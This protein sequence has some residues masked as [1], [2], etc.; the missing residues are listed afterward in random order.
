MMKPVSLITILLFYF[1]L[2]ASVV[3]AGQIPVAMSQGEFTIA[4]AKSGYPLYFLDEQG[5]AAGLMTDLWRLWAKKQEVAVTFVATD[6]WVESLE[7]VK[8]GEIDIHAGLA[9]TPD[10]QQHFSMSRALFSVKSH[11]YLHQKFSDITNGN[12]LTPYSVGVLKGSSN[13]ETIRKYYPALALKVFDTETALFD[14]ALNGKILAFANTLGISKKYKAHNELSNLFPTAKRINF[15]QDDIVAAVAKDNLALADF[16]EQGL[17]KISTEEQAAIEQ[18]W[19]GLGK[20]DDVLTLAFYTRHAP[21]SAISP[22]GKPQGLFIDLWKLWSKHTGQKID[23][24]GKSLDESIALVKK[25]QVDVVVSYPQSKQMRSPLLPAWHLYTSNSQVYVSNRLENIE[26]L[27]DLSGKTLGVYHTAPYKENIQAQYPDIKLAYFSSTDEMIHAAELE[28]IDA[29]LGSVENLRVKLVQNN[30]Q[31]SFRLLEK[32]VYQ[33]KMYSLVAKDNQQ[34][35]QEIKQG[36]EQIPINELQEIEKRWLVYR[37]ESYFDLHSQKV[38]LDAPERDWLSQQASVKVGMV[39]KWQPME[40]ID[41]QGEFR[42]INRDVLDIVSQRT[43]LK[44][45]YTG[46]DNWETLYQALLDKKVDLVGSAEPNEMRKRH[47]LFTDSYWQLPWVILH[48]RHLGHQPS[49]DFFYGKRLAI[50][51]GYD[52]IS[53][54]RKTYPQ[55]SLTLVDNGDDGLLAVQKGLADGFVETLAIASELIKRESLV[56]LMI[57]VVE[58]HTVDYS[59]IAVRKDWPALNSIIDKALLS[60]SQDEKDIIYENWFGLQISTGLDKTVVMR[61]AVQVTI[62]ILIVLIIIMLWNRRLKTVISRTKALQVKMDHMATHD[63]LTGLANRV[64]LKDRLN[65]SILQHHRQHAKLAVLFI[66]LDGFKNI[67]DTHGHDV[68]D[69]L[70]IQIARRLEACVRKSD[71]V[72]RFGGDEFVLLLTDLHK[73]S[74]AAYIA[75]KVLKR[76]QQPFELSTITARIGCSVGIAMYPDDGETDTDLLKVAD[77]LMYQVKAKGKNH[78]R[79]SS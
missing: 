30:L 56:T 24:V 20:Q 53:Y 77:T 37:Q 49:I 21:F 26:N 7:K 12:N 45:Q 14:A 8:T 22:T 41:K 66:D 70:L 1:L 78:F 34:L 72:V 32:P 18:K 9:T 60:I 50:V 39:K 2:H 38:K 62:F 71:T 16:V 29:M 63:S 67:N 64:L 57:S 51:K 27:I 23:F 76:A 13:V 10:R 46:F 73:S 36:F 3:R 19:L 52:M 15:F 43:G 40:F 5:N 55:I 33:A 44:F 61:L 17:A 42:G 11:F 6:K 35:A 59:H 58:E 31:S 65:M 48:Q 54:F 69:E 68:G 4:I 79:F 74:E 25:K 75:G 47:L 28:Q